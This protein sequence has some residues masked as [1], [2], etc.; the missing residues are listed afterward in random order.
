MAI[1]IIMKTY[2]NPYQ[3]Y[4]STPMMPMILGRSQQ[5]KLVDE[6]RR[7][8]PSA[9]LC[10][11]SFSGQ[12]HLGLPWWVSLGWPDDSGITGI[13]GKIR[14]F[15]CWISELAN[16][17]EWCWSI[18]QVTGPPKSCDMLWH[19]ARWPAR[20]PARWL[21]AAL[22]FCRS[23]VVLEVFQRHSC[24]CHSFLQTPPKGWNPSRQCH[25]C[26]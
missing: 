17:V 14:F 20:W 22:E 21:W 23:G 26:V 1:T 15:G 2:E 10:G 13:T 5:K 12:V 9:W 11:W 4:N 25:G 16:Y 3:R 7:G 6:T 24:R 19:G 18:L 8:S